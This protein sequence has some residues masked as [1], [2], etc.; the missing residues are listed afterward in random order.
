MRSA[1]MKRHP[2][3]WSVDCW[4][5]GVG[6]WWWWR[7]GQGEEAL[8]D[9]GVQ[10]ECRR[11]GPQAEGRK[12]GSARGRQN[13]AVVFSAAQYP[14]VSRLESEWFPVGQARGCEGVRGD[15]R[16]CRDFWNRG[17]PGKHTGMRV[18]SEAVEDTKTH[19]SRRCR[20]QSKG[21]D[22]GQT[23]RCVVRPPVV[24]SI[25]TGSSGWGMRLQMEKQ[26]LG[27]CRRGSGRGAMPRR[28]AGQKKSTQSHRR[29][30]RDWF[31]LSGVLLGMG[32]RIAGVL[33]LCDVRAESTRRPCT[34]D[35]FLADDIRR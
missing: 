32:M 26:G 3:L 25:P 5:G 14:C 9:V 35:R 21:A 30:A 23:G 22:A 8:D 1:S 17:M 19:A 12:A 6:R 15:P 11:A 7:E 24:S 34:N 20:R 16:V 13:T 31:I 29:Q 18:L 33:V 4:S 10:E 27:W 2:G 28:S